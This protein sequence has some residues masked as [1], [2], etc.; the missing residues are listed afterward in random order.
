MT[1][2]SKAAE[3][4]PKIRLMVPPAIGRFQDAAMVPAEGA[5]RF[6]N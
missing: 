1:T 4:Q 2:A 3:D 5:P 6:Q